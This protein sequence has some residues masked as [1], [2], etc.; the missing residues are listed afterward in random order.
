MPKQNVQIAG[1]SAPAQSAPGADGA[2]SDVVTMEMIVAL[3]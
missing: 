1:E 3:C 2:R